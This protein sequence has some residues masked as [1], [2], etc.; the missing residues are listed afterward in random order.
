MASLVLTLDYPAARLP[1]AAGGKG[2]SL[3]RMRASGL[4]VP[5]GFV[6]T[7]EAFRRSGFALHE[8]L[9]RQLTA[10]DPADLKALEPLCQA[11]RQAILV[12]GV[13]E[14]VASAV[15][16]AYEELGDGI[17]VSVRS[18][19]TAEDQPWASFAGQYD[20][21]LNVVGRGPLLERLLE[22]WASLY[23]TR[24]VAYRLR[25][26][27]AH[28][29]VMMAVVVQQ[30][31]WP[32]AAGVLFTRD[33]VM[34]DEGYYLI[35]AAFGLGDGVVTGQIPSDT[36][37]LQGATGE[38]LSHAL[39]RKD[40]MVAPARGGGVERVRVPAPR[41]ERPALAPQHLAQLG[42]LGHQ[43]T[44]LF[45]G[46]QDV[47]FAVQDD[48]VW[49][50]QAR[51]ITSAGEFLPFPVVWEDPGDVGYTWARDQFG[52]RGPVFRLQEDAIRVFA[53]GRQVC[54]QETAAP[55][56]RNYIVRFFNGYAYSRSPT[57][58]EREVS[59]RQE[60]HG[61]RDSAYRA[62]GTSLYEAETRPQVE[63]TLAELARFR[64]RRASLPALVEH[65][66]RTLEAYGHV[67]GDLHWRMAAGARFNWPSTYR[68]ITGESE[69]ASGA[70]LQAIPNKTTLLV[71]RLR[72]LARLVQEDPDLS[73][74]FRERSYHRLQE[75]PLR[76][77]PA[78]R[79]FRAR[80]R[81]LL[82]AYGLRTGR[83]FGSG[84]VFAT[85]T[86]NTDPRQPLDFI[87]AYAQQELDVLESLEDSARRDRKRAERRVRRLLAND[88]LR[89]ERF[90]S[91]F[92]RAVE[93]MKRMENHNHIME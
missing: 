32:Q 74:L 77:R 25:L 5:P 71:R 4:P 29:S 89:L 27:L 40:A 68:E 10:A 13:P 82:R 53:K 87:A 72:N 34:G 64:P 62:Q 90:G 52:G 36:F 38:V 31:L 47:E 6:V 28:R 18:S 81:S 56:A 42:R 19:A 51:P 80:F 45:N 86:W 66:E 93:E 17:A 65:L 75:A 49:L 63:E 88:P 23:S 30:Q 8:D 70:L 44:Q 3:A 24:A 20:T 14:E 43:V 46:H 26:G 22:V 83:G 85:S 7:A 12:Q 15:A 35:N 60:R 76:E 37:T 55:M 41:Q 50:L 69:V 73:A 84:T 61:A 16:V 58:D 48:A 92:A 21:F 2:A 79:R 57:V 1:A 78:V 39:A 11:A 54:F 59:L 67:M 9:G 91:E 33:P